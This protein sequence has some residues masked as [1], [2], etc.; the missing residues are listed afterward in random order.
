ME[1]FID[2][3]MMSISDTIREQFFKNGQMNEKPELNWQ[4]KQKTKK[5][6]KMNHFQNDQE[7]GFLTKDAH[8]D[9]YSEKIHEINSKNTT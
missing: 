5:I 1:S 2:E 7:M 8:Y 9:D 4:N 6:K 3:A